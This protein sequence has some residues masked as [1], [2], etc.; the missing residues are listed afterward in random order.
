MT[1]KK[2]VIEY[3]RNQQKATEIDAKVNGINFWVLLGAISLIAW[4]LLATA[5]SPVWSNYE[6]LARVLVAAQGAIFAVRLFGVPGQQGD[7]DRFTSWRLRDMDT[8]FLD[9]IRGLILIIPT[10]FL[11]AFHKDYTA[12]LTGIVGLV[13]CLSGCAALVRLIR[14][15]DV[16]GEKF[17]EPSFGNSQ[18]VNSLLSLLFMLGWIFLFIYQGRLS[19]KLLQEPQIENAKVLAGL[20]ALYALLLLA[21]QRRAFG[22]S[23]RW[24]YALETDLLLNNVTPDVA[25][26]RIEYRALGPRLQ[27]A[28]DRFFDS[29]DQKFATLE[30]MREDCLKQLNEVFSVPKNY[31]AERSA[32]LNAATE[33]CY[34]VLAEID[35]DCKDLSNYISRLKSKNTMIKKSNISTYIKVIETRQSVTTQRLREWQ[36][37]L[38]ASKRKCM[39]NEE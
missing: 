14:G 36:E 32:R 18:Q 17:P 24:T 13:F 16:E 38:E 9:I 8:P 39:G 3:L 25:L 11:I 20:A 29:L 7:S 2:E 27:N 21:I 12:L 34:A 5:N 30:N 10:G 6:L 1:D 28:M 33:R 22:E 4:H 26:R 15:I 37:W 19:I 31:I 35:S 23:S